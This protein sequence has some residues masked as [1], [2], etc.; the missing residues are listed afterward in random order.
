MNVYVFFDRSLC[1]LTVTSIRAGWKRLKLTTPS[2]RIIS[3]TIWFPSWLSIR[4][5]PS[6]GPKC[7][8][9][10]CGGKV[11]SRTS[12]AKFDSWSMKKGS[13]LHRLLGWWLMRR[14]HTSTRCSIKW[15]KVA[16]LHVSVLFLKIYSNFTFFFLF[17]FFRS[18]VVKDSIG[19]DAEIRLVRRSL[20]ARSVY[21][22]KNTKIVSRL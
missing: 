21:K 5:W 14:L 20:R 10:P 3:S 7:P 2:R 4:I 1:Y 13:N 19:C 8:S 15:L 18:F 16:T 17:F 22:K 9:F 6:F 11:L 12:D